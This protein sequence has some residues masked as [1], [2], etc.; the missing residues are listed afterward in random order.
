MAR[1]KRGV[2]KHRR[3]AKVLAQTKGHRGVRHRL[4]RR[5]KESLVKALAYSYAH[6]RERKGDF[7][8]LWILR[9]GSAARQ[10]GL[11]YNAFI[12][13]LK[14]ANVEIDRKML[15]DL[16]VRDPATFSHLTST[17]KERLTLQPAIR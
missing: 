3:H 16:A 11:S 1:V 7:R 10:D 13:G 9:I 12:H 14:L 8:R 5:A 6:R 4:Y 15:A 17:A 2:T